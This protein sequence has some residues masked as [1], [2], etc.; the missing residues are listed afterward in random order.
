MRARAP[1]GGRC[2]FWKRDPV[3]HAGARH[4]QLRDP[5]RNRAVLAPNI[6]ANL[7]RHQARPQSG[8]AN[9]TP[10]SPHG[11]QSKNPAQ[12]PGWMWSWTA[13]RRTSPRTSLLHPLEVRRLHCAAGAPQ[14]GASAA[15]QAIARAT[16]CGLTNEAMGVVQL[17]CLVQRVPVRCVTIVVPYT[18]HGHHARPAGL[19]MRGCLN[20]CRCWRWRHAQRL[21][22]GRWWRCWR[23]FWSAQISPF[24]KPFSGPYGHIADAHFWP[25]F[26]FF[27]CPSVF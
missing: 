11:P 8:S 15:A 17:I 5:C 20:W 2:R 13:I 21:F 6:S 14:G 19:G 3:G 18:R 4:S 1:I 27:T 22:N 10:A 7:V 9:I 26:V 16:S 12:W 24:G 23:P 25:L